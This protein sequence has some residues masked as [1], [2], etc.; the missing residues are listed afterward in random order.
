MKSHF[1][2]DSVATLGFLYPPT[3]PQ[4]QLSVYR[5]KNDGLGS[6]NH[7]VVERQVLVRDIRLM[8][9]LPS[10]EE[11]GFTV[12]AS[13]DE[14]T[15]DDVHDE[16]RL[17]SVY[18]PQLKAQLTALLGARLV[19]LH[20]SVVSLGQ[21]LLASAVILT[22]IDPQDWRHARCH[23]SGQN[24]S[25]WFVNRMKSRCYITHHANGLHNGRTEKNSE[26]IGT[27]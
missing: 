18:G 11:N 2:G 14:V 7:D 21:G 8:N 25:Y 23:P 22:N 5:P 16:G 27:G 20:E 26:A 17:K 9:D 4:G 6:T 15:Y 1:E 10:L 3:L 12:V 13:P 24:Y 19:Y